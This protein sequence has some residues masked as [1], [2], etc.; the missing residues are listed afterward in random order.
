MFENLV[1]AE[2]VKRSLH[3][4]DGKEFWFYRDNSG[5]E[6]D[7]I[8]A[9]PGARLVTLTAIKAGS[10]PK[11][12]WAKRLDSVTTQLRPLLEVQRHRID[13]R[14]VYRGETKRNW[15]TPGTDYVRWD[16]V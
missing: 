2:L 7:L 6:V 9:D 12:E 1:V 3:R 4:G 13:Q 10:T 5:L 8:T 15:P 14:I 11:V 16:E